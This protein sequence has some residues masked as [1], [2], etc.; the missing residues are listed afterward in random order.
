[1]VCC[2]DGFTQDIPT[3]FCEYG[4]T[5]KISQQENW[6][7]H[8]PIVLTVAPAS[9]AAKAGL[10]PYDI[11][12]QIDGKD[13]EGAIIETIEDWMYDINIDRMTVSVSNL[14]RSEKVMVLTKD[15]AYNDEVT[16]KSLADSHA[17][18]SLEDVQKRIFICP[19]RTQTNRD[20]GL[21]SYKTFGFLP[22]DAKNW[23]MENT[24]CDALRTALREQ[25]LIYEPNKPDL[26]VQTYYSFK[27]NPHYRFERNYE[28]PA[29]CRYNVYLKTMQYLPLYDDPE[30]IPLEQAAYTLQLGIQLVDRKQSEAGNTKIVWECEAN[31]LLQNNYNLEEY[32]KFHVPLM[33]MQFPYIYNNKQAKFL[34]QQTR[35]NYTGINYYLNDMELIIKVD[36]QTPAEKAGILGGDK[37]TKIN[38]IVFNPNRNEA[39]EQY[40]QFI[41]HTF[42]LRDPRTLFTNVY[43]FTKCSYWDKLKYAQVNEAFRKQDFQPVFSYLFYFE[44]FINPSYTNK[45]TFDMVRGKRKIKATVWPE[46]KFEER[47]DVVE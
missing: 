47:L 14:G 20:A 21:L 45:V 19:F 2:I 40:K 39:A 30:S 34:Y 6:G 27:N 36:E 29:A 9:S 41:Y 38:S 15:C 26:I 7:Y 13:T 11:I 10:Q 43:G 31:E 37:V 33:I 25:G 46:M 1:M 4:F 24:L 44:P 42:D 5:Y 16:E 28:A 23:D 22:L 8:K 32:A 12:D 35:Y 17:F 3:Y 18:Y